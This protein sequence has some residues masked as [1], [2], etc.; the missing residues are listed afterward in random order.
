[1]ET[2]LVVLASG[3]GSDFQAIADHKR[4]GILTN[5]TIVGLVC[6]HE[7]SQVIKRA[8]NLGVETF[9]IKG[10][11]G[12]KFTSPN[13]K[14]K[15][16][17]NFDRSC[18][19][20]VRKLDAD[21]VVL[22]GFD[23]IVSKDFVE[24]CKFKILNI[25]PA[26]DL[27]RFGGR[28]MVG[29][30]VHELVLK[31]EVQYSGCTIHFVTS[32]IDGGPVILKKRVDLSELETPESLEK[33]ILHIEHIAYPEAIQLVADGRVQVDESGK[34]CYVDRFSDGWDIEWNHRQQSYI[35]KELDKE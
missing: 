21:L 13:E 28:N 25:H 18:I 17:I 27:K 6:N 5:V 32:D 31:S 24:A 29:K 15:A 8:Q 33:K 10:I 34:R 20:I 19:E 4:L 1:M 12:E 3:R 23:Q 30:K 35:A 11:A 9:L 16:R 7:G 26:Y 14:E 22:A 2:K